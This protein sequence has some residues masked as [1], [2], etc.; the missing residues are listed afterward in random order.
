M[1][2]KKFDAQKFLLEKG[3][4]VGLYTA[5]GIAFLLLLT[6]LLWP[7]SGLFGK[8]AGANAA[9]LKRASDQGRARINSATFTDD[10]LAVPKDAAAKLLAEAELRPGSADSFRTWTAFFAAPAQDDSKRRGPEVLSPD[11]FAVAATHAQIRT[12]LFLE[13]PRRV[14]VIKG[15]TADANAGGGGSDLGR[16]GALAGRF[17]NGPPGGPPGMQPPVGGFGGRRPGAGFGL[18]PAGGMGE[19]PMGGGFP[20]GE[21]KRLSTEWVP[22]EK[23]GSQRDSKLADAILPLRVAVVAASFPYKKQLEEFKVKLRYP[24]VDAVF[25]DGVVEFVEPLIERQE[26]GPDGRGLGWKKLDLDNTLKPLILLS[27]ERYELDDPKLDQIVFDGLVMGR[28]QQ[29][30]FDHYPKVEDQLTNIKKTLADLEKATVQ[31]VARPKPFS[32]ASDI[33]PFR[34]RA[35]RPGAEGMNPMG[36]G[37]MPPMGVRPPRGVPPMGSPMG[38][39]M[40]FGNEGGSSGNPQWVLPEHCLVRFMDFTVEPGKTYQYRLKIRMMNPNFGRPDVAWPALAQDKEIVA[41]VWTEINQPV[42]VPSE[43]HYYAVDQKVL[44]AKDKE[45]KAPKYLNPLSPRYGQVVLQA[46]RWLPEVFPNPDDRSRSYP[47]GDWAVAERML[48]YRG[49]SLA[50]PVKTEVPVWD[51]MNETFVL[52][53]SKIAGRFDKVVQVPFAPDDLVNEPLL[54]DFTSKVEYQ[55]QAE[56]EKARPRPIEAEVAT[57]LVILTPD[58]RLLVHDGVADAENEARKERLAAYRQRIDDV[59]NAREKAPGGAE[60]GNPF[61]GNN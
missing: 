16:F 1:A 52:L 58:G 55:K 39:P 14:M 19:G 5:G 24:S 54:V 17:G 43:L 48:V 37:A 12:H 44:D 28:P 51:I 33:K 7:G 34:P 42:V 22:V 23:L 47:V 38:S 11:E 59:K 53:A 9:D 35:V 60:G 32:N 40:G 61:G 31:E 26:I 56:E 2:S 27:G 46:H 30:Q 21:E 57:E 15:K 50:Q 20:G 49:E 29:F 4:Y 10:L 6:G 18:P 45:K 13:N 3:E 25:A 41:P 8:G 36:E